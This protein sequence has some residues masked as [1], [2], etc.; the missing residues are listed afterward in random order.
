MFRCN[1][2]FINYWFISH[3][4]MSFPSLDLVFEHS[5]DATLSCTHD[6]SPTGNHIYTFF[7]SVTFRGEN[8][9]YKG[10]S[11]SHRHLTWL[12]MMKWQLPLH[13][14]FGRTRTPPPMRRYNMSHWY[15][16]VDHHEYL[17]IGSNQTPG[18]DLTSFTY[19]Y[20]VKNC[21][22]TFLCHVLGVDFNHQTL[23]MPSDYWLGHNLTPIL[24]SLS[25]KFS[26]TDPLIIRIPL[27]QS[28]RLIKLGHFSSSP[29]DSSLNTPNS[30]FRP[31]KAHPSYFSHWAPHNSATNNIPNSHLWCLC[32]VPAF[33][34]ELY[35]FGWFP[36]FD[37]LTSLFQG[38]L[39]IL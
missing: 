20:H 36:T 17:W 14:H 31:S 11:T 3:N 35:Y 37:S 28:I 24:D 23:T 10:P 27:F 34:G 25:A 33:M 13:A 39:L 29:W 9:L 15:S 26:D 7:W 16:L 8:Y 18:P 12:Y 6:P 22:W 19:T 1:Y 38:K 21:H 2:C 4:S 30:T 32:S 5:S